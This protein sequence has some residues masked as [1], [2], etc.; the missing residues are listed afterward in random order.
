MAPKGKY[1][2][3]V[4]TAAETETP[5]K[6]LAPGLNI[7]GPIDESFVEIYDSY[8]PINDS[9]KDNCFISKV[10]YR[11]TLS[12]RMLSERPVLPVLCPNVN[13]VPLHAELRSHNT[14]RDHCA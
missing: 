6:E 2:A 10:C 7:L 13:R 12:P 4:S 5:E 9:T 11:V 8:E 3:F 14:L 1:I